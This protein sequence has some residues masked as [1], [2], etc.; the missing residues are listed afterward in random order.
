MTAGL[1][2][3]R[4]TGSTHH[5]GGH[6]PAAGSIRQNQLPEHRGLA[7]CSGPALAPRSRGGARRTGPAATGPEGTRRAPPLSPPSKMAPGAARP[8]LAPS[9]ESCGG[10]GGSAVAVVTRPRRGVPAPGPWR[11]G[12]RSRTAAAAAA[13]GPGAGAVSH[14]R[15]RRRGRG[16]S[17]RCRLSVGAGGFA[18]GLSPAPHLRKAEARAGGHGGCRRGEGCGAA[19]F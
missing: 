15:G 5:L 7:A 14:P 13:T 2:S 12:P 11:G 16:S 18:R 17:P 10:G 3:G 8:R 9:R 1:S 19:P 6:W 4:S